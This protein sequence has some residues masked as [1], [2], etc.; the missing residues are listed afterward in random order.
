MDSPRPAPI[1]RARVDEQS[2]LVVL[3][4]GRFA[5]YLSRL[6]GKTVEV[7]VR[8]ER[9]HRS[10]NANRYY[11][12]VVVAAGSEWS[13]YEPEEFH[14]AMKGVHLPRKQLVLPT[15][16]LIDTLAST[17][18]MDTEAFAEF[19]RRVIVWL[20]GQGCPVPEASEVA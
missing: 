5:G 12:G 9:K 2:K 1:F 11:W 14:D 4:V 7:I 15:G 3:E 10:L 20:A 18:D 13:G 16:E 17:H 8:P 19:V 6:R